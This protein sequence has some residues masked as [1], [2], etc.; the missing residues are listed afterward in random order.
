ME[1]V[2]LQ[3]S[4]TVRFIVETDSA[5]Y[6]TLATPPSPDDSETWLALIVERSSWVV[7]LCHYD[8]SALT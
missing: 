7:I 1:A 4:A 5:Y 3:Q 6:F 2:L 8:L